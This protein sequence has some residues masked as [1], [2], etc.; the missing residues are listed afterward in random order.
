MHLQQGALPVAERKGGAFLDEVV[1]ER[2]YTAFGELSQRSAEVERGETGGRGRR[3]GKRE[4]G[5]E[6]RCGMG[7][8]LAARLACVLVAVAGIFELGA[9]LKKLE[10]Q[11]VRAP[12][13]GSTSAVAL[14][15]RGFGVA[16]ILP[17]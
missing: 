3:K 4:C 5:G 13:H 2:V 11:L 1:G 16:E 14:R 6:P 7:Y 9:A 15:G 8:L 12:P 10:D 17:A